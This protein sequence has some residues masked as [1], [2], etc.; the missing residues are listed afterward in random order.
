MAIYSLQC[1]SSN[2]WTASSAEQMSP[3]PIGSCKGTRL[4]DWLEWPGL[5]FMA[6]EN[7]RVALFAKIAC[8]CLQMI[9]VIPN[10]H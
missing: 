6:A 7:S 1:I 3:S 9:S 8:T 10:A 2:A 4:G 5:I